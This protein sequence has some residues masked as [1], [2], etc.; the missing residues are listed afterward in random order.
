MKAEAANG[1]TMKVVMATAAVVAASVVVTAVV[2]AVA[3]T[4]EALHLS[5]QRPHLM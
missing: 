2:K 3:E 4:M 1:V 5:V